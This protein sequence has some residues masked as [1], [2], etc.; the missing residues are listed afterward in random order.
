MKRSAQWLVAGLGIVG[1][2]RWNKTRNIFPDSK[3]KS[4]AIKFSF[5][6]FDDDLQSLGGIS[7]IEQDLKKVGKIL[8]AN[9]FKSLNMLQNGKEYPGK[10]II[11]VYTNLN[12]ITLNVL[13]ELKQALERNAAKDIVFSKAT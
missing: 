12:G 5:F 4:K 2:F 10:E 9:N 13:S 8:L 3:S 7:E 6:I 1:L 11:G